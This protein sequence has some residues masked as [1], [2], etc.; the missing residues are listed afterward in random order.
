LVGQSQP[1]SKGKVSRILANKAALSIRVDALGDKDTKQ[2]GVE[3]LEQISNR[4]Q[5]LDGRRPVVTKPEGAKI[6][7]YEKPKDGKGGYNPADDVVMKDADDEEDG[8]KDK[9][10]EK[11]EKKEKKTDKKRKRDEE[12]DSEEPKKKK[13]KKQDSSSSDD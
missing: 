4:I 1:K 13:S 5:Q 6:E 10:K 7:K 12:E 3:A 11:K 2:I 8:K 9:K